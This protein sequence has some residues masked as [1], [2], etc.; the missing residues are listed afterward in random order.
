[1]LVF[2]TV[3]VVFLF[4]TCLF[5]CHIFEVGS[6]PY[7]SIEGLAS[8]FKGWW[9]WNGSVRGWWCGYCWLL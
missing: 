3:V 2:L 6:P 1:M 8:S 9:L 4:L 5:T 7:N